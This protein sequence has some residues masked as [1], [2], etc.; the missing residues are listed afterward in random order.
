MT[1]RWGPDGRAAAVSITFD[2]VGE[3]MELSLGTWPED[4]AVGEH[5]SVKRVLPRVLDVLHR[6]GV[7]CTYF[8]E[9]WS[10]GVYPDVVQRLVSESHEVGCHGWQ[11]EHW[12]DVASRSQEHDL[13][14]RT[15]AAMRQH[16]IEPRGFR[17]PGGGLTPWT[18]ELLH[19]AGFTYFSPSARRLGRVDQLLAVPFHWQAIDAYYFF[20]AFAPL[21]ARFGDPEAVLPPSCLAEGI[22]KTLG[23]AVRTGGC[24]SLLFHPFLLDND[25]RFAAM[26]Q[27]IDSIAHRD[28]I[29]CAPCIDHVEWALAHPDLIA[30]DPQL[31]T[32]SWR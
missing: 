5:Y 17:P 22:E 9:G 24:V 20:D 6:V 32:S 28:D 4:R 31:D 19:E 2:N 23:E 3:A 21:R 11:H 25:E 14:A 8:V 29:W 13:I 12:S 1:A 7:R 30:A 16:G 10:A 26:E 27:I 15:V 18:T